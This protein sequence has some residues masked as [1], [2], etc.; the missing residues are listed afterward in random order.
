MNRPGKRPLTPAYVVF[1]ILFSPDTWRVLAGVALALLF[2]PYILPPDLSQGGRVMLY[3][4][5]TAIGWAL[6]AKPAHWMAGQLKK[7]ILGNK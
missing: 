4:M 1:Y 3:I 5:I 2:T 7:L 6:S